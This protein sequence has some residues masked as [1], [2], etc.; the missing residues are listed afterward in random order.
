MNLK[1]VVKQKKLHKGHYWAQKK[2]QQEKI[3]IE[4]VTKTRIFI[5][6]KIYSNY[7]EIM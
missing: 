4:G 3:K 7:I 1:N 5:F 6:K 2:I